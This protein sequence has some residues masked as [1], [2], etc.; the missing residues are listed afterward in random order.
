MNIIFSG[1]T[2]ITCKNLNRNFILIEKEQKYVE[3]I[4]KRLADCNNYL[5]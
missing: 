1:T 2:G 3:I 5:I 4:N